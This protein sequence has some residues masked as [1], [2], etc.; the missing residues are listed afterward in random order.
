M[1]PLNSIYNRPPDERYFVRGEPSAFVYSDGSEQEHQLCEILKGLS[2]VSTFSE[3]LRASVTDW[4]SEYHFNRARHCLLRPLGIQ[5][6]DRVLELGCGCGGITR[7]LGEIG[8]QVTS[9]EGSP[10]RARV[11]AERC[12][13]LSN[14]QVVVDNLLNFESSEPYDWVLII[15]V[16]E[17]SPI[18]GDP[19]DPVNHY[20]RSAARHMADDA[21]LVVAIENKFGL[22]YF[23]GCEEDHLGVPFLGVQGLYPPDGPRTFGRQELSRH[24]SRAGLAHQR[25]LFPFPDYKLPDLIIDERAFSLPELNVA[26]LLARAHARD[27]SGNQLREFD[28]AL[29]WSGLAENGLVSE[30]SNSFLVISSAQPLPT[31]AGP[32]AASYGIRGRRA[33]YCTETSFSAARQGD[34][35][36][37][38]VSK[39]SLAPPAEPPFCTLPNGWQVSQQTGAEAYSQGSLLSWPLL[40]ARADDQPLSTVVKTLE[41]WLAFLL[42]HANGDP[43][44]ISSC[45]LPAQFIDCTPFNL[46]QTANGL[47]YIDQEWRLDRDVPLAWVLCRGVANALGKGVVPSHAALSIGQVVQ[48][49]AMSRQIAIENDQIDAWLELENDFQQ[50]LTNNR[51]SLNG[52]HCPGSTTVPVRR[53]LSGA[54]SRL[55][56]GSKAARRRNGVALITHE[57]VSATTKFEDQRSKLKQARQQLESTKQQL[58]ASQRTVGEMRRSSSWRLTRPVRALSRLFKRSR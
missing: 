23:N 56:I 45:S 24:L 20:L 48:A 36:L 55:N 27:Y 6:G 39:T 14:V 11:A 49:L 35:P 30:M 1:I 57:L 42:R 47:V 12:R 51:P 34:D 3:E 16:L 17:Y 58:A 37:V 4:A 33:D 7:Y 26:D 31:P 2:D 18:Y 38:S 10:A 15:G 43:T 44:E 5:A 52:Q 54:L 40:H 22:K 53:E 28:D 25:F 41:P 50:A 8:A 46:I 29:V 9:V 13:D 19:P 21:R 32:L